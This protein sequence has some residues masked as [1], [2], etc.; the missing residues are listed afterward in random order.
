MEVKECKKRI[1]QVYEIVMWNCKVNWPQWI[2]KFYEMKCEATINI[3]SE[4]ECKV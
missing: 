3:G 1:M 4:R 2:T